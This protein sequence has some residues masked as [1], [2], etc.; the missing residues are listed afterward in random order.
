MRCMLSKKG[1]TDL[2]KEV[3]TLS[4]KVLRSVAPTTFPEQSLVLILLVSSMT[5]TSVDF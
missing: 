5:L 2:Q 1:D 4:F 3:Q